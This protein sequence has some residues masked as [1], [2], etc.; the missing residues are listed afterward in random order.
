MG[1][2]ILEVLSASCS[3]YALNKGFIKKDQIRFDKK[4]E[5]HSSNSD[6]L[7]S[8]FYS[9]KKLDITEKDSDLADRKSVV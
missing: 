2:N 9:D 1:L 5:G 4:F 6:L 8:H 3:A 7:Y